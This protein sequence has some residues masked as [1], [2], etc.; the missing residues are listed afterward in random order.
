MIDDVGF[1]EL[2]KYC[3]R[4]CHVL[5]T[6]TEGRSMDSLSGPMKEAIVGLEGYVDLAH[7]SLQIVTRNTR[8]MGYIESSVRECAL[9]INY[10]QRFRPG[11]T[12]S[13]VLWK[14]KI[15]KILA[16]FDV[17]GCHFRVSQLLNCPRETWSRMI[18]SWPAKMNNMR[19]APPIRA[20]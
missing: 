3:A 17:R 6:A 2:A 16:V 9:D 7:P 1:V 5:K 19:S 10:P 12:E 14:M 11:S 4:A 15:Q 8:A 20:P 18:P 13:P